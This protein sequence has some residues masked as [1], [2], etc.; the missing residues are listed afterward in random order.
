MKLYKNNVIAL[1]TT[2]SLLN[3][4]VVSKGVNNLDAYYDDTSINIESNKLFTIKISKQK[5]E[6]LINSSEENIITVKINN[7]EIKINRKE[8]KELKN[9]ADMYDKENL[10]YTIVISSV[11]ALTLITIFLK[12]KFKQKNKDWVS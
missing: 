3:V 5:L 11:G 4:P 1:L 2:F 6:E 8:L 7:E 10:E 12:E 9:K